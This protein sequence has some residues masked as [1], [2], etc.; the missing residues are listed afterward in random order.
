MRLSGRYQFHS[1]QFHP[2][3]NRRRQFRRG[4]LPAQVLSQ[5]S[6]GKCLLHRPA[7][8]RRSLVLPQ[9]IEHHGRAE[10]RTR[11]IGD[12]F[13]GD[14]RRGTVNGLE[15]RRKAPLGIEI[16]RRVQPQAAGDSARQVAEDVA[17]EI[18]ADNHVERVRTPDQ[19]QRRGVD[20]QF[21]DGDVGEFRR[22]L[23][24][25]PV[26]QAVGV[27]LR[28]GLGD[29]GQPAASRPR[30]MEGKTQDPLDASA[31]VDG[32]LD[33]HLVGRAGR[34]RSAVVHVFTFGVLPHHHQ[35]DRPVARNGPGTPR[36]VWA[37]RTFAYKLSSQSHR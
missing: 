18:R 2:L 6:V 3:G 12:P 37:G 19:V 35:V 17:E 11:G 15:E 9:P 33:R 23:G 31:G 34:Q 7:D 1:R 25:H 24:E 20:V 21:L 27:A 28:V 4:Q 30:Q 8:R 22:Q 16:G 36:K 13:A 29:H 26:P 14:V 32:R 5:I 10:D